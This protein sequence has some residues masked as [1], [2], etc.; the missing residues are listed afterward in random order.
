[1]ANLS[2]RALFVLSV[3]VFSQAC[4]SDTPTAPTTVN[5]T[6]TPS[7]TAAPTGAL[8]LACG[9][10]TMPDCGANCCRM[11]GDEGQWEDHLWDAIATLQNEQ[12]NLFD[13][14]RILDRERFIREVARITEQ[15]YLFCVIPGGPGDEVG[16]KTSNSFS[17]QYDIYESNGRIRFPGY[18]V[19]CRPARF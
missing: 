12:P 3:L 14:M 1:M 9:A 6:P 17:E 4:G 13:G 8:G 11:E 2:G 5:P 19:T 10:S 18:A 16:V 7:A 15:K